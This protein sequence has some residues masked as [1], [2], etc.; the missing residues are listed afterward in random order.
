MSD[1]RAVQQELAVNMALLLGDVPREKQML[2]L[3]VCWEEMQDGW[4]KLD[5]HRLSKY[6]LLVRIIMAEVFKTLRLQ[7]WPKDRL[8]E[9]STILT[10]RV[11]LEA[12]GRTNVVSTGLLFQ[13][14]R[15]FWD[16]LEPQMLQAPTMPESA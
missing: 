13:L 2:W 16:E 11:P 15:L 9:V 5:I 8:V 10:K 6:M 4:E 14:L 3:E 1:K 12:K 7:G